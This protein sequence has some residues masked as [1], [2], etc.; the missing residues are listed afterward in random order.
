MELG[1]ANDGVRDRARLDEV[2]LV[3]LPDVVSVAV[4]AVDAKDRQEDVV[5]DAGSLF[6][7]EEVPG[8]VGEELSCRVVVSNQRVRDVDDGIDVG[9]RSIDALSSDEVDARRARHHDGLVS[10]SLQRRHDATSRPSGSPSDGDADPDVSVR[11]HAAFRSATEAVT[12]ASSAV[13]RSRRR[14]VGAGIGACPG[15]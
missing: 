9:Q 10:R 4:D 7:F 11:A 14:V 2:F 5:S 8:R 13:L 3:S 15:S 12:T 1:S 6:G